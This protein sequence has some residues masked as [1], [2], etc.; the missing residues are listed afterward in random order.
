VIDTREEVVRCA[1][2]GHP[3]PLKGNRLSAEFGPLYGT[4]KNNPALGLFP[5]SSHTVFTSPLREEDVFLLFTDGVIEAM[6]SEDQ[7]FGRDRLEHAARDNLR[8]DLASFTRAIIESVFEFTGRQ[9][10]LDDVCLVAVEALANSSRRT[11]TARENSKQ[12]A[13]L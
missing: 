7:E 5:T 2:A 1:T 9:M 8:L 10:L 3:S 12:G 4:L 13:V 11:A 6:D